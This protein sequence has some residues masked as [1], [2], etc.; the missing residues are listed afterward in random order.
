MND[1]REL[2][3]EVI[4]DHNRNPRNYPKRPA[5]CNHSARGFNPLCGDQLSLHML[6]GDDGVIEDKTCQEC[7]PGEVSPQHDLQPGR[8]GDD[9]ANADQR[10]KC[11]GKATECSDHRGNHDDDHRD[12]RGVPCTFYGRRSAVGEIQIQISKSRQVRI[13]RVAAR[14]VDRGQFALISRLNLGQHEFVRSIASSN[15]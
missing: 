12:A 3:E 4:L 1:L 2:Y 5:G 9:Y 6:V 15:R 7:R 8:I 14:V 13:P 11:L 10:W